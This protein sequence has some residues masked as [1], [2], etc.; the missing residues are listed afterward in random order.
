MKSL[1][2]FINEQLENPIE[3]PIQEEQSP[4]VTQTNI[5]EAGQPNSEEPASDEK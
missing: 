1:S 2:T 3:N 5:Q 4:E